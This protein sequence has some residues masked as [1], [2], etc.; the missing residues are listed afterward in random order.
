MREPPTVCRHKVLRHPVQV[1]R[2][3]AFGESKTYRGP[4]DRT[5]AETN[6]KWGMPAKACFTG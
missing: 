4:A 2:R 5:R 6:M 1:K 3:P